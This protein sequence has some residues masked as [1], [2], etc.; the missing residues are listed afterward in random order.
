VTTTSLR[1]WLDAE[2]RG[3]LRRLS[4]SAEI[5]YRSLIRYAEGE[6]VPPLSVALRLAKV[7]GLPVDA[8]APQAKPRRRGAR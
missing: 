8:L 7:T 2:G 6:R 4:E 5:G 1:G 3:A